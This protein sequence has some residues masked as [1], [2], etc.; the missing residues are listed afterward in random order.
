MALLA[1]LFVGL[2]VWVRSMS[3]PARMPRL[4]GPPATATGA[5]PGGAVAR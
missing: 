3:R 5:P 4:L 1:G 2:L